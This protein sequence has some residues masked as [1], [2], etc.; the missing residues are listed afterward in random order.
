MSERKFSNNTGYSQL[1]GLFN[2]KLIDEIKN[3]QKGN[4]KLYY[5][6]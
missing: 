5:N 4:F 2:Q 1:R 6:R 3:I